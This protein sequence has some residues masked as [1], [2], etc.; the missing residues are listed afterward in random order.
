MRSENT[1][2]VGGPLDG[3][4]MGVLVGATGQPPK[5]YTV[6]VPDAGGGKPV[7]HIYHREPS[8]GP[9]AARQTRW[10]FV[11]DP[12]GTVPDTRLKWPWSRSVRNKGTRP[13]GD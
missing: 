12:E 5:V 8:P 3:R 4:L 10:V 7:V 9:R 13:P 2:F 6:P 1:E 11:Y